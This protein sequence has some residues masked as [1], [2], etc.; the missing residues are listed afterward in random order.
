MGASINFAE[1]WE[2][3]DDQGFADELHREIPAGHI[4][5]GVKV[6]VIGN[7][8]DCDDF[9]FAL[10][11]GR[12]AWVHLTWK[13]ESSPEW[14]A[15][16]IYETLEDAQASIRNNIE[17]SN[18]PFNSVWVGICLLLLGLTCPLWLGFIGVLMD[19]DA[20]GMWGAIYGV[21][22][23]GVTFVIG[24]IVTMFGFAVKKGA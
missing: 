21:A 8:I 10:P 22:V 14:P 1:P 23:G 11:N 16:L 4:L 19:G 20:G 3:C 6:K 7:R 18:R 13:V 15:T 5:Y 12:F 17:K 2:S 9:L 24:L